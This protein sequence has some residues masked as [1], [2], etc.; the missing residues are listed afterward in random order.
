MSTQEKTLHP[1]LQKRNTSQKNT[2]KV[3]SHN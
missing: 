2:T 3:I 1:N